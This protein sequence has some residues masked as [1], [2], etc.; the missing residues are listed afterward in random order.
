[1]KKDLQ[2]NS[3]NTDTE[4]TISVR[5]KRVEIKENL[6]ALGL[7][8][9]QT[10]FDNEVSVLGEVWLYFHFYL[11]NYIITPFVSILYQIY[12]NCWCNPGF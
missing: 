9:K 10:V 4:G 5:I 2:S 11:V 7:G 6:W 1:M 8:T 12:R 3:A